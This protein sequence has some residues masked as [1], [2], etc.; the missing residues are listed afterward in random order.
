VGTQLL[1]PEITNWLVQSPMHQV[2]ERGTGKS[3]RI[4]G[5]SIFGKTGTAQKLDPQT[6]TYSDTAWV[7]SFLCGAPAENPSVIVLL[8][9]DEATT[10][11]TH[12][13]GTVAAPTAA[14]ILQFAEARVRTL[15]LHNP[16]SNDTLTDASND[17][18][19]FR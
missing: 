4:P 12:Y 13:G 16:I 2:V 9:V 17:L 14:R 19:R 15:G 6:G 3:A 7:V 5:L 10:P 8:M 11:G 1:D 18:N